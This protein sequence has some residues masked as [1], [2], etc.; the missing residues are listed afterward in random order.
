MIG[1]SVFFEAFLLLK[2]FCSSPQKKMS[3]SEVLELEPA[4][5]EIWWRADVN[6]YAWTLFEKDVIY[7]AE[8]WGRINSG[9][10][11]CQRF[12]YSHRLR[13]FYV[14]SNKQPVIHWQLRY[15]VSTNSIFY[16][17]TSIYINDK[18]KWNRF[19]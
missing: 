12:Q 14:S 1:N 7:R 9:L 13:T 6:L 2:T 18:N 8:P 17:P 3:F 4:S 15:F 11:R 16:E 5:S 19:Y 10:W